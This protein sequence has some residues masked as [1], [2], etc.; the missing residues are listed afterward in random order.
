MASDSQGT[1]LLGRASPTAHHRLG[2][3]KVSQGRRDLADIDARPAKRPRLSPTKQSRGSESGTQGWLRVVSSQSSK[4]NRLTA[5]STR[6]PSRM[7]KDEQAMMDDLLAGLDA[8]AFDVSPTKSQDVTK[9]PQKVLRSASPLRARATNQ[10]TNLVSRV[11]RVISAASG[12]TAVDV[13]ASVPPPSA[14]TLKVELKDTKPLVTSAAARPS[15]DD[16]LEGLDDLCDFDFGD[17]SAFDEDLY[18]S[19]PPIVCSASAANS[20]S[21]PLM[22]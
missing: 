3:P 10:H 2:T 17:L 20:A 14:P 6:Q 21:L 4:E 11:S 12:P 22:S 9:S 5:T 13:T 19:A 18:Q 7:S 1:V 8:S 15:D 16:I